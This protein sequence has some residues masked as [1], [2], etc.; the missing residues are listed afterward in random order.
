MF[1]FKGV[2]RWRVQRKEKVNEQAVVR[3]RLAL[4][5]GLVIF[6]FFILTAQL[7]RLQIVEGSQYQQRAEANHLRILDV[8]AQRGVLYDRD[9]RLLVR[10]DPTFTASVV[11]ADVPEGDQRT[12]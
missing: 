5:R 2:R 8:P 3:S 4:L 7:W 12:L 9:G 11:L 10:N 6:A 1:F